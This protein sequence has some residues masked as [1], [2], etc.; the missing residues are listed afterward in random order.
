MNRSCLYKATALITAL[1]A[2][3][4][5]PPAAAR[6]EEPVRLFLGRELAPLVRALLPAPRGGAASAFG[7]VD[8]PGA[9]VRRVLAADR[10]TGLILVSSPSELVALDQAGR[11]EPGTALRLAD[12][13]LGV[14]VR[15][16]SEARALSDLTA[17]AGP[18]F[19]RIG[20]AARASGAIG[21]ESEQSL[22]KSG[23]WDAVKTRL[24]VLPP[25]S[26]IPA[27]A[28][29]EVDAVIASSAQADASVRPILIIPENLH[30]PLTLTAVLLKGTPEAG[31]ARDLA[32]RLRGSEARDVLLK[33][34]GRLPAPDRPP[35][36]ELFLYCGAGLREA[37]DDLI[38]EFAKATG[39]RVRPTYTGSGCLLAQI[40]ISGSGDLYMPG[41]QFYMDQAVSRGFVREHQVVTYF[42]PVIMVGKGNPKGI[43]GLADLLRPGLRLGIGEKE[44]TAIGAFTPKLLAEAKLSYEALRKNVVASFATAP[45]MGNAVKLGAVDAAIQWDAV[46]SWYLDGADVIAFPT[47]PGTISPVPL[48]VLKFSRRPEAAR[49]FLKFALSPVGRAIFERHGHSID[50]ARPTFKPK[51]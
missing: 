49:S 7:I 21:A 13:P 23:L 30:D 5:S 4:L 38:A 3:L 6:A 28:R 33:A 22:H 44:S 15:P 14:F 35:S 47:G 20:I 40:A 8:G 50:P 11:L 10:R 12:M 32:A 29:G 31:S 36:G 16:A 25:E 17:L 51:S 9:D 18:R 26:L 41:E 27:A 1:I 39:V 48:G 34:G 43:R 19:S 46:A 45:E 24:V 2:A 37:A 42:I